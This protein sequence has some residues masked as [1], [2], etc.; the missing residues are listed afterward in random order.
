MTCLYESTGPV[1]RCGSAGACNTLTRPPN[2]HS[3][4]QALGQD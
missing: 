3:N 4:T 1:T 2:S